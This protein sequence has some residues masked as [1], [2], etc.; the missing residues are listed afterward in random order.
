MIYPNNFESKTGFGKIRNLLKDKCLGG[1][2]ACKVEQ[3]QYST[4]L[5]EIKQQLSRASEFMNICLL[6]RDFPQD[7]YLDTR[8]A[9]RRLQ[10]ISTYLTQQELFD[11]KQSC[12]TLKNIIQFFKRAKEDEY[13]NLRT[14]CADILV[15]Q[16]LIQCMQRVMD[17][18][19]E[20]RDDASP[21]LRRIRS[22]IRTKSASISSVVN[23]I[24]RNAK[25][26]GWCDSDAELRVCDGKLLIPVQASS[27]RKISGVVTDESSTGKTS[28]IEPL[29]SIELNN[30]V[31]ELVFQEKREITKILI[32]TSEKIKP[33]IP[34]LLW[35]NDILAELDFARAKARM[36]IDMKAN[37]PILSGEPVCDMRLARHPILEATLNAEG[38]KAV[39]LDIEITHQNRIIMISG[40]N[41]GGKS[42]C[43]KTVGII[44]YMHQCGLLT[45]LSANSTLGIFKDI[46]IDIGDEQSIENDLSTYSS[47]LSNM[48]QFLDNAGKSSLI[49]ID[50]FGT[51]TEPILGG[52]IAEAIL[53]NLN[54]RKVKGV[55]T[56]HYTNLKNYA[57][58]TEGLINGAMMYDNTN[59]KP[60]FMLEIGKIGNSFAF[61]MARKIGI[62][63]SLLKTAEEIAGREHID[64]ERRMQELEEEKRKLTIALANASNRE[65]TLSSQEEKYRT[66]TEYTISERK[67]ILK[68]YKTKFE[69]IL[70][71]S[72]RM[73]ERTVL[74]IKNAQ[75]EKTQTRNIRRKLEEFKEEAMQEFTEEDKRIDEIME[76]LRRKQQEKAERRAKKRDEKEQAKARIIPPKEKPL[77]QGDKVVIDDGTSQATI[78]DIK[79]GKA[80]LQMGLMQTFVDLKRLKR[81]GASADQQ[82]NQQ[83]QP[84]QTISVNFQTEKKSGGFLYGLD[85]RGL[86]GDEALPR[87]AKYI[88]EALTTGH[89]EIKILHGTG[90]GALKSMIREYLR[91][92]PIVKR[93]YDEKVDLGGAGITVV[94]L[95]Y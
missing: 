60:L 93:C 17:E 85:V 19:G 92:Q 30:A 29:E 77:K 74:D 27:K 35:C 36:A 50:E 11:L 24:L 56:T 57:T 86:R 59:M 12:D 10:K 58:A 66:E 80:L 65:K 71:E 84:K 46:F 20:I 15:E 3:M 83:A 37:M 64:Y 48:K 88:D 67:N 78:L 23:R 81:I 68:A 55:I 7:N 22:E 89:R 73:I 28:F 61:E 32:E 31:R 70:K 54:S 45:P 90:T 34:D 21:E 44:Q 6:S 40:P 8:Q 14:L 53:D 79:D 62:S 26:Q 39:P 4:D 94:E 72:N 69:E 76:R 43:L 42:V 41:A 87:V 47:H 18:K 38:K 51:G 91:T 25:Q 16:P 63:D 2:G 49:L 5:T 9:L 75:A 33:Y 1:L 95:D 52:A 13:P 82:N